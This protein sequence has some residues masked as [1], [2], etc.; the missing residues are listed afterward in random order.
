MQQFTRR[1][2]TATLCSPLVS[3]L[4]GFGQSCAP[5]AGGTPIPFTVP[6][7]QTS[8]RR[9]PV[10]ALDQN[11]ISRLRLAYQ[12]LRELT[13]SAP[14]DP[15]GW[16]QQANIHCFQ[17]GGNPGH[18]IHQSWLF[19]PWHRAYLYYH[20]KILGKL[21][22][23]N[24]FRLPYWDWDVVS[25][26]NLPAIYRPQTVNNAPNSLFDPNRDV[27]GGDSMPA[28]I[29]PANNNPMNAPNFQSFGGNQAA[30]GALENGPH[31]LIH[32]W[33]G[34]R[35]VSSS[36]ADM[37]RLDTAARDPLFFAHHCNIDR[38]WAEWLRR[39]PTAHKN[40]TAPAWLNTSFTFFDENSKLR[41]I[42]VGDVLD[43]AGKLG[44]TYPPGAALTDS[45]PPKKI[46]LPF[47]KITKAIKLPADL[48]AQLTG[49]A[50]SEVKKNRSLVLDGAVLPTTTGLYFVFA[51][52]AP[53]PGTDPNTA[54]NYLGY[55]G[56]IKGEHPHGRE[57]SILLRPT[58]RFFELAGSPQG[59]TLT[60]APGTPGGPRSAGSRLDFAA[61]YVSE[62]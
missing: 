16:M 24:S 22:N 23:D 57:S 21:I 25:S 49:A 51:G 1:A 36:N 38:L 8:I 35:Q 44:F 26:R 30:G 6:A 58:A 43:T 9:K 62:E 3:A 4:P 33:T 11:E 60:L 46:P 34:D 5:P 18:D 19:F 41:R 12:K 39:N 61:V 59:A 13:Q 10:S 55:V 31:G 52:P 17:C 29:F 42:R 37:G 50:D 48:K 53:A 7:G 32:V 40:P 20:E 47:D 56:L 54:P 14:N 28:F 45:K 27:N 2:F 15:R